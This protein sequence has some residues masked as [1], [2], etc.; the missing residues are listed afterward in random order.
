MAIPRRSRG[1]M[2]GSSV[3]VPVRVLASMRSATLTRLG[4]ELQRLEACRVDGLHF[5]VLDPLASEEFWL[6]P[7]LLRA[8]RPATQLPFEVHLILDH[9]DVWCERY[10]DAGADAVLVHL[11]TCN[12]PAQVL[13]RIRERRARAGLAL[14]SGT[15]A[16]QLE[17]YLGS[18]DV[19]NVM[20]IDRGRPGVVSAPGVENL[21]QVA[22]LVARIGAETIIQAD[23]AVSMTTRERLVCAGASSLVVGYPLFSQPDFCAAIA[24]FRGQTPN[25]AASGAS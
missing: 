19:V 24:G 10:L 18:C 3:A 13:R 15:P 5:D 12:Q 17:P 8:L 2:G 25:A 4:E 22:A 6:G 21:R 16:G 20:T 14:H 23:G 9:P 7:G 11:E 1:L